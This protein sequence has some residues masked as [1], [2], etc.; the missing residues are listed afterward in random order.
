MWC[1]CSTKISAQPLVQ[2]AFGAD[3]EGGRKGRGGGEP[4]MVK[5]GQV[6]VVVR[7]EIGM[8]LTSSILA[9]HRHEINASKYLNRTGYFCLPLFL[10][11]R[12]KKRI[13]QPTWSY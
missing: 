7:W 8:G 5:R 9:P 10:I 12:W 1:D 13:A 11:L 2:A 3:A 6:G 4:H